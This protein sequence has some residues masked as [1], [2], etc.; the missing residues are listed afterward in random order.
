VKAT[1]TVRRL[2]FPISAGE[3]NASREDGPPYVI[4]RVLGV[5]SGRSPTY[6]RLPDPQSLIDLGKLGPMARVTILRPNV[7]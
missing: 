5:R 6:L 4:W 7:A 1:S 3:L 2:D